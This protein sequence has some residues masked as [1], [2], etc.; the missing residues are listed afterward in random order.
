MEV[1]KQKVEEKIERQLDYNKEDA[2][3]EV[4]F[5]NH[6]ELMPAVADLIRVPVFCRRRSLKSKW[7]AW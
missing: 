2:A 4:T 6:L 1:K 3:T 5:V 7:K